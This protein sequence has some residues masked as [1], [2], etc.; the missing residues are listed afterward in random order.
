[1]IGNFHSPSFRGFAVKR[2]PCMIR[3]ASVICCLFLSST[4]LAQLPAGP[5]DFPQWRGPNRDGISSEKGLMKAW[6][7]EGP[8]I[9]WQVDDVGVGYSSIAIK[10]GLIVTM[11]DLDGVEHIIALR[12]SDGSR[13]WAVQPEPLKAALA[14]K[15]NREFANIDR[16]AD[17]K[18][19]ELEAL[20][21]LGWDYLKY[22]RDGESDVSARAAKVFAGLDS[23]SD[24]QLSYAEAN[25]Q[26]RDRFRQI[27]TADK[28]KTAELAESRAADLIRQADENHDGKVD[29]KESRQNYLERI[30]SRADERLP[31]SK[32]GD[33][34]L[35]HDEVVAYLAKHEAGQDGILTAGE[36]TAYYEKNV[37]GGDGL[38]THEELQG[39]Y[40]GFRNGMG[41]GPRGTP[42]IDGDRVYAEGGNGDLSCLELQTGKTIWHVSLTTDL[43]GGRPGWGYSESPL[44]ADDWVIVTP[45]GKAGTLAALDKMTGDLVWQS[46]EN[47]ESAHYSSPILAT[48]GGIRQVVQFA[49]DSAF[50]VG[51]ADGKLM[52]K[53]S[54]ANNGT[55]NCCTPIVDQDHVFVA[56]AYGTGGGLARI[57]TVG[58][59]QSAREVY[60]EKKMQIHHGGIVKIGDYMYTNGGGTLICI[61]FLTGEI[62][63]QDRSVGKGSLV[64]ADGMLYVLSE[65]QQLAL[66]EATPEGYREHG[67]IKFEGQGRPSWRTPSW[68]AVACTSV[69]SRC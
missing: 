34:L 17:G 3:L 14:E 35:T 64:A 48:I 55:A 41:D 32:E 29:R 33:K 62:A 1:M 58:N 4:V 50:G 27:D 39:L 68:L 54:G 42:T 18:I 63:W 60:F 37:S 19:E 47:T 38:L 30:F 31:E 52:W 23:N 21:R 22:D 28:A 40:G 61:H 56:S 49:R 65:N 7:E 2:H 15:V 57:S 25:N 9:L 45:G 69:I 10:D 59:N 43:G 26:L 44:I 13:V 6:P 20:S 12:V 24:G 67:R 16:N 53:Y 66:V 8:A 5:G 51:L 36:F 46:K 11:G